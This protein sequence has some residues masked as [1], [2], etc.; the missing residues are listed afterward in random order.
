[1]IGVISGNPGEGGRR[2]A[3]IVL[4]KYTSIQYFLELNSTGKEQ[5]TL[6]THKSVLKRARQNEVRNVRNKSKRTRVKSVTKTVHAAIS[7]G[8]PEG[9]RAALAAAIPVIDKAGLKGV[10]HRNTASRKISKLTKKVNAL[11]S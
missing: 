4:D 9:A 10:L 1:M 5:I 6:A 11:T 7:A 3:E 2:C 8:S